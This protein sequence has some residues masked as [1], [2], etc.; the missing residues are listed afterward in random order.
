MNRVVLLTTEGC[1]G[2]TIMKRLVSAAYMEAK[3]ENVSFGQYDFREREVEDLVRDNNI[4]DF[5]TTLFI[6]HNEI[7]DKIVGSKPKDYIINKIRQL[8]ES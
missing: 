8:Q 4:G 5:P 6:K 1:E 7:V 2:C 3:V